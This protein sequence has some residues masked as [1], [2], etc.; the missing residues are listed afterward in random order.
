MYPFSSINTLKIIY[1]AYFH[2]IINYGI[3][4]WGNSIESKKVFLAQKEIIRIMT[5][6]SP[7]TSCKPLFQS[8]RIL[9][10]Y[11]QY[12]FSLMKFLLQNQ[13][14]FTSNSE[15]HNINTR[16]KSKL[17]K[18]IS[19]ITLYQ[20]GVYSMAIR[21]FNKLPEYIANSLGNKKTFIATLSQYVV[22]KSFYSLAEF[23][24]D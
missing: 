8:L 24:K 1:F 3:I 6:S 16:N 19:N 2:S 13:E 21:I 17:Y 10:V 14:M 11:S 20:K 12:I 23:L 18:P 4:F 15:V 9:T 22:K 7:K 5:G